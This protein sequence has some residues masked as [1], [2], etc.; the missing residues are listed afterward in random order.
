MQKACR[1]WFIILLLSTLAQLSAVVLKVFEL[2]DPRATD[3][4]SKAN[5]AVVQAFKKKFPHIELR[6][7]SGIKID[8]MDL[9]AAPLMAIAGGVAPDILYVNLPLP[10]GR[11][12]RQGGLR[13]AQAPSGK[14]CLAGNQAQAE[15]Q[16]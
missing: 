7:F 11:I 10:S 12:H 8:K 6:A 14:A 15:G 5:A 3:A 4:A 9:D 1:I 16:R 13:T 2:P